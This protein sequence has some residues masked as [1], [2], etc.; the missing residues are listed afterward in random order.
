VARRPSR[1][2]VGSGTAV[3]VASFPMRSAPESHASAPAGADPHRLPRTIEPVSYRL[4]LTPDLEAAQF[5]GSVEIDVMVLEQTDR[6]V[7]N[8]A[9]LDISAASVVPPA[10]DPVEVSASLDEA[11]QRLVLTLPAPLAKGDATVRLAFKGTLNDQLRGFYRSTFT[12]HEGNTKTIAT[13]QMEATDARRAFPCWD[14]PDRKATFEV[15]LVVD[16]DLAAYSNSPVVEEEAILVGSA[17]KRRVRFAP[18]MKMSSYLVAF[19][20]GPL[21]ATEPMNVGGVPV[22]VVH[23]PGKE[24]LSSFALDVAR[25]SLEFFPEYFGIPYPAEKL[26]LVAIPDFAYGAMENLG[27]VTFRETALLVDPQNAAR[28]E[29]ERIAD[30][31]HHEIAH[32]WF[33]D[34]VT[35]GWWEGIWLNEAFATFMEMLAT[36]HY[37]PDWNRW[38]SFGLERDGAMA[39]DGLHATRPIEYPVGSPEEADGMFDTLT[40]EKGSSVLRMLEQYIGPEVFRS[41]VCRYLETHAYGNTVTGDLWNALEEVSGEPIRA[42]AESWILQGGH[43][44]VHLDGQTLTQEPF[45]YLP[46]SPDGE[47]SIGRRWLVPVLSRSV[48]DARGGDTDGEASRVLLTEGPATLPADIAQG[49]DASAGGVALVNAGG[50]GVYRVGYRPEHRAHLADRLGQ[51]DELERFDLLS[52]TWALVLAG[53]AELG[54]LFNLAAELGEGKEPETYQVVAAALRLCDRVAREADRPTVQA[55]AR[56]LLGARAASLGWET[57]DGEGER[58]PTL[59]ALLIDVLGTAGATPGVRAEAVRRFDAWRRGEAAVDADLQSAVLAVVADH[60]REGD[61]DAVLDRYHHPANP[62]DERR[63]LM[64]LGAFSDV[65]LCSRSFELAVTE[66]RRQDGPFLIR[67]LL[68]NRVGGPAVWERVKSEWALLLDRFPDIVHDSMVSTVRTL[69]ADPVL[70]DDVTRFLTDHPLAVGQRHV[71]Q[72]L[73]QLAVNVRF[74]ER[75]REGGGI[76]AHLGKVAAR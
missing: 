28:V 5:S 63:H 10:G 32:M 50:W 41:G 62:Q 7:L 25:H 34:L 2:E 55:A 58:I 29:L 47:S 51:L 54:E 12:D 27:C 60:D 3:T 17:R 9:E 73:E 18:T 22:R 26:D 33:G 59:R 37:R 8:A 30:V 20:V 31:I 46:A 75:M 43:P 56:T 49:A 64:A 23:V 42:V 35:M 36:D 72:T 24:H 48:S 67:A 45:A 70:A 57:T 38:T 61:Y 71:V 11:A 44:I 1:D 52:D 53:R 39:V 13:T 21:V 16:E 65:D 66:V 14:E 19:V 68:A 76:A 74:G 15:T 4:E 69:C 40:Y 6:I